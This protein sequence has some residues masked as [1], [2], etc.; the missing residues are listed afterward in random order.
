MS[1]IFLSYASQ[2]RERVKPIV[3]A[4]ALQGWSVWWDRK[5]PFGKTFDQIIEE[6][7]DAAYCVVVVW[8][9]NSV[10]SEWVRNPE[11][12]LLL[13]DN[14]TFGGAKLGLLLTA[15]TIYWRNYAGQI[16]DQIRYTEIQKVNFSKSDAFWKRAEILINEKGIEI[17][18]GVRNKVAESLANVIRHL[19]NR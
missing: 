3:E 18:A 12:V 16:F 10:I 13:Y 15:D 6:A 19:A 11:D 4:L 1:D 9:R 2:D 5:I 17:S 7:L 14:T 8:S